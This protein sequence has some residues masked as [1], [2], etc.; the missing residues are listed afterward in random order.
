MAIHFST[1]KR[2]GEL[3]TFTRLRF[4]VLGTIQ[5]SLMLAALWDIHR[6]APEE[7]NGNKKMWYFLAFVNWIGPIAYFWKGR[8]P[9]TS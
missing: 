5:V 2:W 3:S 1:D 7:L 8:K 4:I 6:R 9:L